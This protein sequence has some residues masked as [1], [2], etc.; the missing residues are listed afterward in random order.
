MA[1]HGG[2]D[3]A[4]ERAMFDPVYLRD[5]ACRLHLLSRDC[6]DNATAGELRRLADETHAKAD[7]AEGLVEFLCA[8]PD[9][10]RRRSA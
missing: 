4:G 7:E 5:V 6:L 10:G 1:L 2:H 8:R 9:C 3:S